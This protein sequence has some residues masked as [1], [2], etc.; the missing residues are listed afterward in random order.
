M[1]SSKSKSNK[2]S[3][4]GKQKKSKRKKSKR[5]IKAKKIIYYD[6]TE[7]NVL[8]KNHK[9]FWKSIKLNYFFWLST[10]ICIRLLTYFGKK[11]HTF[12][13]G[14][15][16]FY[17]AILVGYGI[18]YIS[19]AY[20]FG[21]LYEESSFSVIKYLKK[22]KNID[23]LIRFLLL[24]TFDFH[25]KIHHDTSINKKKVNIFYEFFQNILTEGG[26]LIIVAIFTNLKI[27]IYGCKFALN[28]TVILLWGI[29]YAT[30]HNINYAFQ[31]ISQ[32]TNHHI[33]PRTNYALDTL[34]ILFD[35]K[36]DLDNI[37]NLNWNWGGNMIIITLLMIYFKIDI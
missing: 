35:T 5:K 33:D 22:F 17:F 14:V 13:E 32:H 24:Y 21:K 26:F 11:G 4:S 1:T 2:S 36:Y 3:N 20:D 6:I 31:K 19:H 15:I 8:F 29:L 30:V 25:D 7:K 10:L 37:E 28:K 16:S 23:R 12:S 9:Y 27:N 34:D 18:H